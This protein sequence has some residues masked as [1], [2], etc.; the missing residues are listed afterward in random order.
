MSEVVAEVILRGPEGQSVADADTPPMSAE[1]LLRLQPTPQTI[2]SARDALAARG[3][4]VLEEGATGF[5]IAA[6][7]SLFQDVFSVHLE[8]RT[9]NGEPSWQPE[10][11]IEV[12]EDLN[13]WVA[14]VAFTSPPEFF[15]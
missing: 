14:T 12:P 1:E 3:F 10:G 6:D 2:S 11:P 5:G 8:W 9:T 4:R 13:R 15:L 7:R